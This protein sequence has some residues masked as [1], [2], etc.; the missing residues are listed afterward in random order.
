MTHYKF[1]PLLIVGMQGF[2]GL[3]F[4]C[5]FLPILS[6]IPCGLEKDACV[7]LDSGDPVIEDLTIYLREVA[8]NPIILMAVMVVLCSMAINNL[9]GV[10][11][12]QYANSLT[13]SICDVSRTVIIWI[14]GLIVTGTLGSSNSIY[15]W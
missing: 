3:F 11:I 12:A 10:M 9:F 4:A 5:I 8:D 1:T 13:R 2:Y 15:E 7:Y 14:V 6:L